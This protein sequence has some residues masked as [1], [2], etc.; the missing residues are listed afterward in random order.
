MQTILRILTLA[1]GWKPDLSLRIENP[2]YLPL[3]IEALGESGPCGLAALSV[4]H[5][6][7]RNGDLMRDPEMCFE[8]VS[9]H[10]RQRREE[11][12]RQA[13]ERQQQ[14]YEAEVASRPTRT[15]R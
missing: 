6:S 13:F 14:E 7:E 4:A 11:E 8:L 2:P 10:E 12:R 3:S 1:G 15:P 5:Y 9:T